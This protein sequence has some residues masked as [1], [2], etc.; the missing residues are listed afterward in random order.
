MTVKRSPQTVRRQTL[1]DVAAAVGVTVATVSNAYNRPDQLSP[2]LR[3]RVL[4]TA[5]SLGYPGPDPVAR[6]LRRGRAG[7]IGV[8]YADRLS[9]AFKDP[10]AVVFLGGIAAAAEAAGLGLLLVPGSPRAARDLE[11]PGRAAVDGF[12]IYSMAHD[13][14][15]LAAALER[16]LPIVTVD[17]PAVSGAPSVAIDDV[18]GA[19]TA[20]EHL[21]GLGHRQF[22]VLSLELTPSVRSGWADLSRQS[23]ASYPV[24]R[25][26]LRGYTEALTA[27]GLSW[28]AVPVYECVENSLAEGRLGGER[29]LTSH[30]RPTALLAMSDMLALGALDA[31]R[32]LDV[33]VPGDLSIVGS[34]DI[35]EGLWANPPLTTVHEPHLDKGVKAGEL[36]VA[37]LAG[38]EHHD[39]VT[40]PMHL[41]VR[42]STASAPGAGKATDCEQK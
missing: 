24:S 41:V 33:A 26:R 23:A 39:V 2:A 10:V 4:E 6:G 31:A 1:K 9:Y 35:P 15:L 25:A 37:I 42:A 7:A 36:L 16:R 5:R 17:M 8:L 21:I 22:G 34:D 28:G 14:P 13:D 32:R 38:E 27:A 12:V 18:A 30:S 20:A 29:L 19:R 40:L 11:A 3:E